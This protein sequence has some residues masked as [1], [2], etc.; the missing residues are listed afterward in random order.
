M[1][2]SKLPS[3]F[4]DPDGFLFS[5]KGEIYRQVNNSY[6]KHYDELMESGLYDSL[7]E[8]SWLVPH[9]EVSHPGHQKGNEH[10]YK[11]LYPEQIPYISYP[12]EWCFSQLKDAA[13]LTLS[14][15]QEALRYGMTL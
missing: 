5:H 3:S 13:I 2:V 12:Y 11:I 8:K 14:I 6:K 15:Q 4:R 7:L 1:N 10:C 9:K